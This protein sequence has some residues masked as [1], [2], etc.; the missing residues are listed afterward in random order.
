VLVLFRKEFTA[1]A[2]EA[3]DDGGLADLDGV[4]ALEFPAVDRKRGAI[5]EKFG[6]CPVKL[7]RADGFLKALVDFEGCFGD[8][9]D[10]GACES[11]NEDDG[12]GWE[13][14]KT[15]LQKFPDFHS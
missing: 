3:D 8:F 6:D 9:R 13:F 12:E 11:G 10:V 1:V 15:F 2:E 5:F 4:E 14:V 7:S